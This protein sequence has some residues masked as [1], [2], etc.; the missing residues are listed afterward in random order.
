LHEGGGGAD[1]AHG[2]IG[3][4]G[5]GEG[6]E[7]VGGVDHVSDAAAL[8]DVI[9]EFVDCC[10]FVECDGEGLGALFFFFIIVRRFREEKIPRRED[11]ERKKK[12]KTSALALV[13]NLQVQIAF[14]FI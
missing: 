7:D 2:L 1:L 3:G 4:G 12:F 6:F 8:G 14:E 11:F 9:D 13:I 5:D 10:V